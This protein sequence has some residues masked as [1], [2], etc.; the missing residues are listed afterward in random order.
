MNE[1]MQYLRNVGYRFDE[2][3]FDELR[4]RLIMSQGFSENALFPYQAALEGMDERSFQLPRYDTAKTLSELE[5]SGI[6]CPPADEAL[7]QTYLKYLR[8]VDF[9]PA[10]SV[11]PL[12]PVFGGLA[13]APQG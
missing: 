3:P 7:L 11:A 6:V 10:P 4:R 12:S 9:L 8:E 1:A 2:L 13:T 5:G